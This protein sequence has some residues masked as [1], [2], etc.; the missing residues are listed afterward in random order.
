[1]KVEIE[2]VIDYFQYNSILI[3]SMFG[4]SVIAL[5]LKY[6]TKEKS[7]QLLFT[8]YR[9]SFLDPLTYVRFFTHILGHRNWEHLSNNYI[10]IL[11]IG[12][13]LEE[14]YGTIDLLIMILSTAFVVAL[15]NFI[16]G[17]IRLRGASCIVFMF[18]VLSSFCN[19]KEGKIPLTFVLIFIFYVVDEIKKI[20][21]EDGISHDGH[22]IGALCGAVFGIWYMHGVGL[23]EAL[24][25]ILIK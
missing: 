14:K 8:T 10:T 20:K 4:I 25:N 9:S 23:Y 3:L 24:M 21:K 6:I 18:I 22:V 1:M 13:M 12:P 19:I 16:R 2:D 15:Y 17:G 5:A 11:L 7:D